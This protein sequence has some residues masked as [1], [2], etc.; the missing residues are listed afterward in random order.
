[1]SEIFPYDLP[2]SVH[3][4]AGYFVHAAGLV[5]D[6]ETINK[7][8][9]HVEQVGFVHRGEHRT[10]HVVTVRIGLPGDATILVEPGE[11]VEWEIPGGQDSYCSTSDLLPTGFRI[12]DGVL[13]GSSN[14]PGVWTFTITVGPAIK[15]DGLGN[16]G[17]P[18]DPGEWIPFDQPRKVVPRHTA[19]IDLTG[20]DKAQLDDVIAH[21]QAAK[22]D[23]EV[24][25]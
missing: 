2:D 3:R 7:I 25:E 19:G 11:F 20:L 16:G 15:F 10:A 24:P 17:S 23:L 13:S 21:A 22:K 9:A 6:V 8:A 5:L 4:W 18:L 1:M 14:M 12:E